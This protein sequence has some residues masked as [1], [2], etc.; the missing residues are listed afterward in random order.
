M[1]TN[2][3]APTVCPS[4]YLHNHQAKTTRANILL[5]ASKAHGL[6]VGASSAC[7]NKQRATAPQQPCRGLAW[8]STAGRGLDFF[9]PEAQKGMLESSDRNRAQKT[10]TENSHTHTHSDLTE[11]T[12][13][14]HAR[15][16]QGGADVYMPAPELI[17]TT[18][19]ARQ[20][21]MFGQ[22]L[23]HRL[24]VSVPL[25]VCVCQR[26]WECVVCVREKKKIK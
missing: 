18:I 12:M 2:A 15:R 19:R 10:Q 20:M 24:S 5:R 16:D 3:T 21:S 9:F 25:C 8:C 11:L 4:L 7:C 1:S 23:V 14:Q 6:K 17:Q 13:A 26:S 22:K